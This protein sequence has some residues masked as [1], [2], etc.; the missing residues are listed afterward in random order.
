MALALCVGACAPLVI[1]GVAAGSAG[2]GFIAGVVSS[3]PYQDA[4]IALKVAK[5]INDELCHVEPWKPHSATI[6]AAIAAFCDNLPSSPPDLLKQ[7]AAVVM[8]IEAEK[9][10]AP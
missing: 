4:D 1:G 7:A 10:A 6:Q 9:K 8:A 2:G 3:Q 5:P